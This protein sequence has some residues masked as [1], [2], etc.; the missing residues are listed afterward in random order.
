V[1][2]FGDVAV[3]ALSSAIPTMPFIA[4]GKIG[5][6]QRAALAN[7]LETLGRE[8]LFRVVL[9]HH[10]PLPGQGWHRGLR[11]AGKV[12]HI[13]KRHGVELVLHG[14]DHVHMVQELETTSGPGFVIGVPSASEAV[15]GRAPAAR[16]NEY[17]IA[18]NG[19]GWR[20]EMV[21]RAVAASPEHVW[22]CERRVLRER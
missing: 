11:D 2:R 17:A 22:E 7:A 15:A 13:F 12:K 1:R 16:Y 6:A 8:G 4:A 10:P 9:V 18:R 19:N 21:G 14:H 3:V 5:T 20:V